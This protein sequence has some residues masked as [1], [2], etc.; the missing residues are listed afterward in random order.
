MT[1]EDEDAKLVNAT[2][3]AKLLGVDR[4]TITRWRRTCKLP[5]PIL[6]GPHWSVAQ[7]KKLSIL[8]VNSVGQIG[9]SRDK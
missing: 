9:T 5:K 6:D 1:L 3:L 2:E 7:L 8:N 4:K